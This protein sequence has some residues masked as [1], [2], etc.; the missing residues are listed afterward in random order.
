MSTAWPLRCCEAAPATHG[1]PPPRQVCFPGAH[2]LQGRAMPTAAK[3]AR[4]SR[5]SAP[6]AQ[7]VKSMPAKRPP[8]VGLVSLGC[9]KALVDSERI[10]TRLRSEGYELSPDY[11]GADVVLV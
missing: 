10:V 8:R 6:A 4:T 9:P 5:R 11:A 1:W 2:P 7:P 3:S